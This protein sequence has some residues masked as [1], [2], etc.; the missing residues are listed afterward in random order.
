[1]DPNEIIKAAPE[2]AK[3]AAVLGASDVSLR[4]PTEVR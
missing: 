1:M 4:A 2:I 3:S